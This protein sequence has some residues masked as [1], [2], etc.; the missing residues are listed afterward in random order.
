MWWRWGLMRL[1][2]FGGYL[3]GIDMKQRRHHNN[4]GLSQTKK[5]RT[6]DKVKAIARRLNIKYG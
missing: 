3:G 5:G 1:H 2:Q 4:K 6:T